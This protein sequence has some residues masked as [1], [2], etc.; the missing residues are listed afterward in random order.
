LIELGRLDEAWGCLD[1]ALLIAREAGEGFQSPARAMRVTILLARGRLD[2]AEAETEAFD[3][4]AEP[5]PEIAELR[6]AQGRD[7]EAEE[8]WQRLLAEFAAGEDR[9]ERAEM[10][11]GYARFLA[12]RGHASEAKAKLTEAHGLVEGA[13]AK[14]YERL[15]REAKA[16]LN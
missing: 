4:V 2:E 15:I 5:Y 16:L 1:N 3:A 11:V 8:I 9:L 12:S 6:A 13:E 10:V 14:F 7:D